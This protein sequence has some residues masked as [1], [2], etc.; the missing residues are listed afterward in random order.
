MAANQTNELST[1]SANRYLLRQ[2]KRQILPQNYDYLLVLD[3]EATCDDL[4]Q[5]NPQV[6]TSY[7][8]TKKYYVN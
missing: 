7:I 4:T 3:F 2:S 5:L 1:T 6:N 8:N